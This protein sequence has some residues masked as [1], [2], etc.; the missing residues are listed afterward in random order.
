MFDAN[1]LDAH[2]RIESRSPLTSRLPSIGIN[3]ALD[4]GD[5]LLMLT[6]D[7]LHHKHF[8]QQANFWWS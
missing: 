3:T 6:E 7:G 2:H 1:Q 5:P 4:L 8:L